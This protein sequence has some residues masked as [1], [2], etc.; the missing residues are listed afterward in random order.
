MYCLRDSLSRLPFYWTSD[1]E[2][3]EM[4]S[5]TD[6]ERYSIPK[7]EVQT[8]MGSHWFRG[9]YRAVQQHLIRKNYGSDRKRYAQD[10]NYPE[11]MMASTSC[12]QKD[13]WT[14]IPEGQNVDPDGW[15]L[16]ESEGSYYSQV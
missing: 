10:H 15:Y 6:W 3:K 2:G 5:E 11:L 7:L 8:R 1:P 4:I 9:E 14:M 16:V 13:N 12:Q